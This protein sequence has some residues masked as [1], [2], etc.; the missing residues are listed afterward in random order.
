[1]PAESRLKFESKLTFA[2]FISALSVRETGHASFAEMRTKRAAKNNIERRVRV[3]MLRLNRRRVHVPPTRVR[4]IGATSWATGPT[5]G[6]G[7]LHIAAETRDGSSMCFTF[8]QIETSKT[9]R[10]TLALSLTRHFSIYYTYYL[11]F[12]AASVKIRYNGSERGKKATR[13]EPANP[14]WQGDSLLHINHFSN[15]TQ[16]GFVC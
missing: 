15:Q 4:L 12:A 1:M 16:S 10:R 5:A 9:A 13:P 14:Y 8:R 6:S 2:L 3:C 11:L 7:K